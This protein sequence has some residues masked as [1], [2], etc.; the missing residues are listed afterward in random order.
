MLAKIRIITNSAKLRITYYIDLTSA[1]NITYA[2]LVIGIY[3]KA[4]SLFFPTFALEIKILL[5]YEVLR[6]LERFYLG[7]QL[8]WRIS[9]CS[10]GQVYWCYSRHHYCLPSV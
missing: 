6:V 4:L 9:P 5:K 1:L 8:F 3:G 2:G 10:V 7:V